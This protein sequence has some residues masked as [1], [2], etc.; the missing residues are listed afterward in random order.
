M[1]KVNNTTSKTLQNNFGV[2]QASVLGPIIF[3]IYVSGLGEAIVGCSVIQYADDTQLVHTGSS[4]A[5]PGL[6]ERAE[7]TLSLAQQ[8]FTANGLMLNSS[9]TQCIFVGTRPLIRQIPPDTIINF[10]NNS[11][12]PI[13]HVKNLGLSLDF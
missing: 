9:K 3:N 4:D 12:I 1:V 7:A 5:F 13:T 6:I 10:D 8:Y 2:P 11:V